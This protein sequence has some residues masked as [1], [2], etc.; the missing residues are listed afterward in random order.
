MGLDPG[1]LDAI[2]KE[3][4]ELGHG[5]IRPSYHPIAVPVL[6][7]GRTILVIWAPGGQTRPYKSTKVLGRDRG[8]W[9][10]FIR[11][12]SCTVMA[13]GRDE[14]ELLT[15]AATVPFDDR[16]NQRARV[17]DLSQDECR[18]RASRGAVSAQ[19]GSA[20]LPS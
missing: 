11:K 14:A 19:C 1:T 7:S 13:R 8:K 6:V 20:L 3:I 16:I 17:A 15:L 4:L 10:Y 5:A 9:A 2:Q 18:G 12:G